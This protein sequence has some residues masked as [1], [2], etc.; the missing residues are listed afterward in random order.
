MGFEIDKGAEKILETLNGKGYEAYIVGGCV[1]DMIM[2]RKP[3]DWDITTSARPEETKKCFKRTFDTGIK[4]GTITV[5]LDGGSYEVTT[6]RIEGEYT[7]CRH[8][9]EVVFTRDIHEDLLRRDFTMNAIAYHPREGFIDPFVGRD[10]IEKKTIRGVGFPDERFRE[11]A[12]RMLRAV[13]FAAQLGFSVE[14]ETWKALKN[15]AELIKKVSAERIREELQKLIMSGRPEKL[16]LLAESGLMGYIWPSLADALEK[17]SAETAGELAASEAVPALRWALFLRRLGAA[18]AQSLMK[19]L[20]FD[21]KTMKSVCAVIAEEKNGVD[22]SPYGVKK[23][24]NR[25]GDENYGLFL[26]YSLAIGDERAGE[27]EKVLEEIRK[28]GECVGLKDLALNGTDIGK[29]GVKDG[30]LIGE[31]LS[32]LLDEAQK[33]NEN[34]K[35]EILEDIVRKKIDA[36]RVK[37][38]DFEPG[39]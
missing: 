4:H 3:G 26:K 5:L 2:G 35:R 31:I 33:D 11:D 21:T 15:R 27:A 34:N 32:A 9:D 18:E 16:S 30:R 39:L 28:K 36:K 1:R 7:D 19:G 29:M 25:L 14:E 10:D 20:K 13:R 17:Y 38:S 24:L 22:V 23:T 8:P 12:L 6:Y 37:A